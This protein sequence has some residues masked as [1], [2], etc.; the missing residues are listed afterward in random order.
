MTDISNFICPHLRDIQP[1]VPGKP[2][3]EVKRELGLTGEII[4][5]A[6]NENTLGPSPLAIEAI[7][8]NIPK[9]WMYPD[10]S[11]FYLKK[12]LS[13]YHDVPSNWIVVGNGAVE[14]IF[15]LAQACFMPGDESIMGQPA[16]MMYQVVSKINTCVP[17]T[18]SH[19]EHRNDLS[20]FAER[21]TDKT[22]IIWIDNPNNPTGAYNTKNEVEWFIDQIDNRAIIVL[23][24]AYQQFVDA[25][26][27]PDGIDYVKRHKNVVVLR[28][29]SKVVGLAGLRCGYG[30][31]NPYLAGIL[32]TLRINFSVNS[33]AQ[34]AAL[35][36]MNDRE[37]MSKSRKILIEG[38]RFF[39][40]HLDKLGLKY[41]LTQANYVWIEFGEDAKEINEFLLKEGIIIRPGWIFGAPHCVRVSINNEENNVKFFKILKKALSAGVLK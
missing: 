27:F 18:V 26:D 20:G 38:R 4:K 3:E 17:I 14:V 32:E 36:A 11:V 19:P 25:P 31:M 6:S 41:N 37:H 8:E 34:A 5:F 9:I 10:D 21:L 35:A 40:E 23:D 2:I 33:L 30:I 13:E 22:K 29:F 1:Y 28:T 39:Y 7:I 16:F 15:L 24:E 12:A